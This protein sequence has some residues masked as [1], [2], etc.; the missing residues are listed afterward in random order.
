MGCFRTNCALSGRSIGYNDEVVCFII[1]KQ[2]QHHTTFTYPWDQWKIFSNPIFGKYNDYGGVIVDNL[3]DDFSIQRLL[4]LNGM[5]MEHVF[6]DEDY[7]S[8]DQNFLDKLEYANKFMGKAEFALM[9][10]DARIYNSI[11]GEV[12]D[13]DRLEQA[14]RECYRYF[15]KIKIDKDADFEEQE[16]WY[17]RT[18]IL[19]SSLEYHYLLADNAKLANKFREFGFDIPSTE[20]YRELYKEIYPFSTIGRSESIFDNLTKLSRIKSEI[21]EEEFVLQY[22]HNI[23]VEKIARAF[24]DSGRYV[25]PC[26]YASQEDNNSSLF[27][28]TIRTLD[29]ILK[30]EFNNEY[31]FGLA[32]DYKTEETWSEPKRMI[33]VLKEKIIQWEQLEQ[34]NTENDL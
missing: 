34:R 2:K 8:I 9:M 18:Q 17:T 16:M 32:Y 20:D 27:D 19:N 4:E 7:P 15:S 10:I 3:K 33:D 25:M 31:E 11:V 29:C 5:T 30:E 23:H 21:S 22:F 13:H 24:M 1:T 6:E 28:L 26:L 14:L 12:K